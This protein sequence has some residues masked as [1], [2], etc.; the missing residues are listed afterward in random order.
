MSAI[1]RTLVTAAAP[2]LAAG[3]GA[4]AAL[5]AT[6][7]EHGSGAA[8]TPQIP[9]VAK[10]VTWKNGATK[11]YLHV[12]G[13]SKGNSADI[14]VYTGSGSCSDHGATDLQCAEEWQQ[15]STGYAHEFAF[16]NVNSGKCL[17]DG[18]DLFSSVATQYSCATN[19]YPVQERWRYSSISPSGFS[20]V[21]YDSAKGPEGPEHGYLCTD[22]PTGTAGLSKYQ[23]AI[24]PWSEMDTYA[25][26]Y[27]CQWT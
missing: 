27:G 22:W 21:L 14:N 17:D 9:A 18:G 2:L 25:P 1:R 6:A 5:A 7:Q 12:K 10:Y 11:D 24:A 13:G 4:P 15:I 8:A 20:G 19:G 23:V 3:A 16:K 26:R